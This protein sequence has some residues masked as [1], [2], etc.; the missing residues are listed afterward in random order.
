MSWIVHTFVLII[1]AP[2]AVSEFWQGW[3]FDLCSKENEDG[4]DEAD[5]DNDESDDKYCSSGHFGV[6]Y[7]TTS[8]ISSIATL[9][10]ILRV[11]RSR[12]I[13]LLLEK[14]LVWKKN[15]FIDH[16]CNYDKVS[17]L[18]ILSVHETCTI[19]DSNLHPQS[20][21]WW[22]EGDIFAF[23]GCISWTLWQ[24]G[25][26]VTFLLRPRPGALY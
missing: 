20:I 14:T 2:L 24:D 7:R 19:W 10:E 9:S 4:E 25:K 22:R 16:G 12:A 21:H 6:G 15:G 1:S 26:K 23:Q 8:S 18:S 17:D 3:R 11:L 13:I 5:I